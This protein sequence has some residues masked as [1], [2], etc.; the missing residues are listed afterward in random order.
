MSPLEYQSEIALTNIQSHQLIYPHGVR[1]TSLCRAFSRKGQKD[2]AIK[3]KYSEAM[4]H[5]SMWKQI[6]GQKAY[7]AQWLVC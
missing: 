1:L 6:Q 2:N 4:N 3:L 5:Y 7:S